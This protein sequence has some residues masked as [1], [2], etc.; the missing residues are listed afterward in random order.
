MSGNKKIY[1][2]FRRLHFHFQLVHGSLVFT[3]RIPAPTKK[4]SEYRMPF[5]LEK[6]QLT[7]LH[8]ALIIVVGIAR[9]RPAR[10]SILRSLRA[11]GQ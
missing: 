11:R 1:A 7:A 5:R 4:A 9:Y 2:F 6:F 10:R 8:A 3:Q